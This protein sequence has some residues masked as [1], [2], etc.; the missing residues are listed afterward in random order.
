MCRGNVVDLD[1]SVVNVV[2]HSVIAYV[3]VFGLTI[4]G[5]I[6]RDLKRR[7]TASKERNRTNC[8]GNL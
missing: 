1:F 5:R 6:V 7:L 8:R 2:A 3:D 4:F